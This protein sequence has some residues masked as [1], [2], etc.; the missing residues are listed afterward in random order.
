MWG[1]TCPP[2]PSSSRALGL[3]KGTG[4]TA[5]LQSSCLH[6]CMAAPRLIAS[7]SPFIQGWHWVPPILLANTSHPWAGSQSCALC[8][9]GIARAGLRARDAGDGSGFLLLLLCCVL[10]QP[11]STVQ[12]PSK[13]LWH[14]TA[15]WHSDALCL[16]FPRSPLPS[17]YLRSLWVTKELP[18]PSLRCLISQMKS[19]LLHYSQIQVS[20]ITK[21]A[22]EPW[23]G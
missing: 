12:H 22:G 10:P 1:T 9:E 13:A 15:P 20:N 7:V 4:A 16:S 6:P 17:P 11:S 2:P 21:A 18:G 5:P 19:I 8:R 23:E 3:N 14:S